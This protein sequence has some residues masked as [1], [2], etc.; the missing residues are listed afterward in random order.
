MEQIPLIVC[1]LGFLKHIGFAWAEISSR[2][3]LLSRAGPPLQWMNRRTIRKKVE[4]MKHTSLD[5]ETF[6]MTWIR[7]LYSNVKYYTSLINIPHAISTVCW[8]DF[9]YIFKLM[10][11]AGGG[12]GC[13]DSYFRVEHTQFRIQ[14]HG[15]LEREPSFSMG[16]VYDG[17]WQLVTK[18]IV[19]KHSGCLQRKH[20]VTLSCK[21]LIRRK[22][23]DCSGNQ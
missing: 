7:R 10:V 4:A 9:H 18:V 15:I 21:D 14:I 16:N 11:G 22:K 3:K 17:L 2:G 13:H 12:A 5:W 19:W 1:T 6:M 23:H 8:E 20:S